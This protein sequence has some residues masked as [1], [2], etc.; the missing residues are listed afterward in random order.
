M[1]HPAVATSS[2]Y[3]CGAS[4][5]RACQV[6]GTWGFLPGVQVC[7]QGDMPIPVRAVPGGTRVQASSER[8]LGGLSWVTSSRTLKKRKLLHSQVRWSDPVSC[9]GQ[10]HRVP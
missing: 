4:L 3:S 10:E 7:V 8:D 9:V 6:G 1:S 2:G 5:C